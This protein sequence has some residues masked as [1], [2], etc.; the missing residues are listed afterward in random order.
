MS[1]V[2]AIVNHKGGV[3][4]T[5]TA[6]NLGKGLSLLKNK[7]LLVDLDPQ[8]NLSQSVGL[9]EPKQTINSAIDKDK[10]LPVVTIAK[11]FDIIP[12]DLDLALTE[13]KLTSDING[14]FKL[15]DSLAP[16]KNNYDYILL[17][18]PPNLSILTM[19]A[20]IAADELFI[21]LQPEKLAVNGLNTI[22]NLVL[23]INRNLNAAL[24]LTGIIIT[25]FDRTVIKRAIADKVIETFGNKVF[26]TFIRNN[27]AIKEASLQSQDIFS[28]NDTS[29]GAEDYM[30]LAKEL[31]KRN[32]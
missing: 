5:T 23:E 8:A 16:L 18:C 13:R 17:D 9:E 20:L 1:A 26:Q 11:D 15:R 24:K 30:D 10:P 28:Y 22:Q 32:S 12:A 27:V 6:L 29:I 21:I 7:V 25:Q 31:V 4:K 19:N 2:I 14:Y 3:G